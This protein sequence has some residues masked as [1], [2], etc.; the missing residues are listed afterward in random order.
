MKALLCYFDRKFYLFQGI[1]DNFDDIF[2]ASGSGGTI[3][4][5]ALANYLNGSPL[6]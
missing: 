4:G 1:L 5:L 3:G 2:V 6:K